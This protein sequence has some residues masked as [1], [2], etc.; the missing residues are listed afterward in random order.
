MALSNRLAD[1]ENLDDETVYD[2]LYFLTSVCNRFASVVILCGFR[3]VGAKRGDIESYGEK[4]S[5]LHSQH[6]M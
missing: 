2:L 1:I 5:L 6:Q 4:Y 3:S